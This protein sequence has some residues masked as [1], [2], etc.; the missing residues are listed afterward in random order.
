MARKDQYIN[1]FYEYAL[2]GI[3]MNKYGSDLMAE[4][5]AELDME[6]I[7][8]NPGASFR[9]LH[10]SL[11]NHPTKKM[12]KI[13]TCTHEEISIAIAHGYY[14]AAGKPMA[15]GI[16]NV[17]GLQHASM[18]IFNAWC[19]RVPMLLVGGGG[20]MEVEKRRPWIDWIHSA[21]VQGNLVRDFV[22]YDD[23]P[24][25]I[26]GVAESM[27]RAYKQAVTEPAGP[28]YVCLDAAIQEEELPREAI[29]VDE[30]HRVDKL[31]DSKL[32][33]PGRAP[34]PDQESIQIIVNAI[35]EAKWPV[36]IADKTTKSDESFHTLSTLAEEW[37]I[38]VIDRGGRFNIATNHPMNVT[39]ANIDIL[40]RADVVI[41]L[42]VG[43]IYRATAKTNRVTR[44]TKSSVQ[45]DAR[46]F[47][48]GLQDYGVRSWAADYQQLFPTELNIL[49]DTSLFI[50]QVQQSLKEQVSSVNQDAV[51]D[52]M[53]QRR[54][55]VAETQSNLRVKWEET[56]RTKR[57]EN[58]IALSVLAAEIWEAIKGREF[59]L[60]NGNLKGWAQKL[61]TMD[62]P[63]QFL[64]GDG[65]GG[66]GYG[67]GATIGACLANHNTNK[68]V[69]DIQ[70]DGDLLFTSGGLWTLA[71]HDLPAL[72]VMHN[73]RSYYNSEEHQI[74]IAKFRG[75]DV[76]T[77][78]IGTRIDNPAVNFA[79]LA[80]S[81]GVYGIGP[82]ERTEDLR[83]ALEKAL[84]YMEKE[85]KPVLIDVITQPN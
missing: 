61:F 3:M 31:P 32:Y 42:D 34:S 63:R 2:G 70:S 17:V 60:S 81:M 29:Q 82:I 5:I 44:V 64:G 67:I 59:V 77:T 21:L 66:L 15:A 7:A 57:E 65:G 83:P 51:Q 56:I 43:D 25:S 20:P 33:S 13:I 48:I 47:S 28:V 24:A 38:P 46:V 30:I 12:P 4:I 69:V 18:A 9:G 16:H 79:K 84:K 39:S 72:V 35:L 62:Q 45:P 75:R 85:K 58:P 6:F 26:Y 53:K 68:L 11:I 40:E 55:V 52:N 80:D 8:F 71:H 50:K 19:D 74:N 22:K 54:Q 49:G 76:S 23:Q 73:N 37:A 27:Y 1:K 36:I 10:D 78:G 41:A 14:K